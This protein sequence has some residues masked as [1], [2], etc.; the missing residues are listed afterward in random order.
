M[1]TVEYT[2]EQY[3]ALGQFLNDKFREVRETLSNA[4]SEGDIELLEQE[5][6]ML[7]DLLRAL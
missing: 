3:Y 7:R 2:E 4:D 5:L 1:R 6:D